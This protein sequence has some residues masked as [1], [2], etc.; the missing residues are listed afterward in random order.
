MSNWSEEH[1]EALQA[2]GLTA[3]AEELLRRAREAGTRGG[4]ADPVRVGKMWGPGGEVQVWV[5]GAAAR[6]GPCPRYP[7]LFLNAN[8]SLRSNA[9]TK[10]PTDD[11]LLPFVLQLVGKDTGEILFESA[12]R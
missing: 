2:D 4:D 7:R 1:D 10:L 9:T 6:E 5:W 12:P 11:V 3:S 8:R